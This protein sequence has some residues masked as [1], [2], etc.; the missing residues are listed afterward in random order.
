VINFLFAHVP[1]LAQVSDAKGR[2]RRP[3]LGGHLTDI[4]SWTTND[5]ST[6]PYTLA[7]RNDHWDV[8]ERLNGALLM[9]R[10]SFFSK[11]TNQ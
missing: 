4:V 9:A 10:V 3:T 5:P 7:S 11:V 6:T 8:L 2:R 1:L